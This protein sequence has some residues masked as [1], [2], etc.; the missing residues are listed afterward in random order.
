[1]D[2]VLE[3][4]GLADEA[5]ESSLAYVMKVTLLHGARECQ[6]QKI[7][8][9]AV[10]LPRSRLDTAKAASYTFSLVLAAA[11]GDHLDMASIMN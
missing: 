4:C 1:M 7:E 2:E 3:S 5:A 8:R 9:S 6:Q 10:R 11:C